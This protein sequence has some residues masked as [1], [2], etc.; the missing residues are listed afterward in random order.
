MFSARLSRCWRPIFPLCWHTFLAPIF[1]Q[2]SWFRHFSD[3]PTSTCAKYIYTSLN[4]YLAITLERKNLPRAGY[5]L[6]HKGHICV[7]LFTAG[8]V[9][10]VGMRSSFLVTGDDTLSIYWNDALSERAT[11]LAL[12]PEGTFHPLQALLV[13]AIKHRY[14]RA[15]RNGNGNGNAIHTHNLGCVLWTASRLGQ[16]H[17][18]VLKPVIWSRWWEFVAIAQLPNL[19]IA[20]I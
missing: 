14:H 15:S 12:S 8:A 7:W 6:L 16:R 11:G 18:T 9:R 5:L 4:L 1:C 2:P 20:L 10:R 13:G 19:I 3:K 17:A